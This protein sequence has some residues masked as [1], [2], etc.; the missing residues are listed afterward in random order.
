[1]MKKKILVFSGYKGKQQQNIIRATS[2]PKM[3]AKNQSMF[4]LFSKCNISLLDN[5]KSNKEI[6]CKLPSWS[7]EVKISHKSCS[8]G[9]GRQGAASLP[10]LPDFF[11]SWFFTTKTNNKKDF[12]KEGGGKVWS[13][14]W[15]FLPHP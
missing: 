4:F 2:E 14:Y 13:C 11:P 1:M 10:P 6:N 8:E 9:D 7:I 5:L 15:Y 3:S 12:K